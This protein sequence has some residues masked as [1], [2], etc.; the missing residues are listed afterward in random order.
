MSKSLHLRCEFI[1]KLLCLTLPSEEHFALSFS[2]KFILYVN[3]FSPKRVKFFKSTFNSLSLV[4][5]AGET[6]LSSTSTPI[7][8]KAIFSSATLQEAD[9][10]SGFFTAF[11]SPELVCPLLR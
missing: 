6:L 9:L 1:S 10:L 3:G 11:S 8:F 7:F 5:T 4:F 2:S